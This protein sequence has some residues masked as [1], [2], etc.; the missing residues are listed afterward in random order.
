MKT[1]T[2]PAPAKLNLGL[3]ICGRRA[4]G[5]HNLQTVFQFIDMCDEL[6][7]DLRDDG[8]VALAPQLPG[9]AMQDNLVWRAAT[10]L[11]QHTQT[12]LGADITLTKRLPL[13]GGIGG[14][15]SNA[16]TT[17]MALNRLWQCGLDQRQLQQL[18]LQLGADVPIFLHG[19]A[20]FAEGV[21]ERLTDV[22][23]EEPWYL[24]L[25]P[26]VHVSTAQIFSHEELTRNSEIMKMSAFLEQGSR[27]DCE[28]LVRKLFPAVD[29]A[30]RW[31][32]Q[33]G[34][35]RLT[36]TGACVYCACPSHAEAKAL[37]D[38]VPQ[39]WHCFV[40]RGCNESPLHRALAQM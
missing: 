2:L 38:R 33:Y 5:Y 6:R 23:P 30:M 25:V 7:F 24:V 13:G 3:H 27:N 18:G 10:L 29:D 1:L 14:G 12:P 40:A 15:S 26:Q 11:Q 37:A 4:D 17:L 31:L 8:H 32:S 16:A 9:V 21:G 20:A 36:G 19:H 28:A 22:A 35:A 39:N 34:P